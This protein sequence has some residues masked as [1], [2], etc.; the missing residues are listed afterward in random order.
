MTLKVTATVLVSC[1]MLQAL[2]PPLWKT[3]LGGNCHVSPCTAATFTLGACAGRLRQKTV[4]PDIQ[5]TKTE[6]QRAT[7]PSPKYPR[8][9]V[10][11]PKRPS[12]RSKMGYQAPMLLVT[13]VTNRVASLPKY[14]CFSTSD[15]TYVA[16]RAGAK[17][18]AFS[19]TTC[20][21]EKPLACI[22][23]KCCIASTRNISISETRPTKTNFWG[24]KM[25]GMLERFP[26]ATQ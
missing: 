19:C 4:L 24:H 12:S 13:E 7:S 26:R 20:L 9:F 1:R 8:A 22:I 15:F 11:R 25:P 21:T 14:I 6:S 10:A 16:P 17:R 5:T 2:S 18:R 3:G 23:F